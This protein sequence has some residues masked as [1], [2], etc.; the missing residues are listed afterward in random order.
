MFAA[1]ARILLVL[2]ALAGAL[3]A[4]SAAATSDYV[5]VSQFGSYGSGNGQFIGPTYNLNW[6]SYDPINEDILVADSGN[7]R[8]QV[9]SPSGAYLRQFGTQGNG[10]GQFNGIGGIAVD[11]QSHEIVVADGNQRIQIFSSSGAYLRQFG[12]PGSGIGQFNVPGSVA[13]DPVSR[14]IVVADLNNHRVQMFN[15]YGVYLG[16]FGS[17]GTGD[18]EFTYAIYLALDPNSHHILVGDELNH[19]LQIFDQHGHYLSQFGSFG[20]GNGQFNNCP[21]GIA[22]DRVTGDIVIADYGNSRVEVFDAN[23]T[24]LSQFGSAGNGNGQFNGSNGPT[25]LDINQRTHEVVVL[26]RGNS[27]AE[28]FGL[29]TSPPPPACGPTEVSLSIEPL[30][31]TASQEFFFSAQAS[32]SPP[33]AGTVS[34]LVDGTTSAACTASMRDVSASCLH[35]LGLGTHSVIAQY[36]GDGLDPGGCSTSQVVTVV[37]DGQQGPTSTGCTVIP[38]PPFEAEPA[39]VVCNVGAGPLAAPSG[40]EITGYVEV[41]QGSA[42]LDDVPIFFGTSIFTTVLSGGNH[43]LTV[44]YSGDGLNASS[45]TT[46]PISVEVPADDIFYGDFDV[47][48]S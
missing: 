3:G 23:G 39:S 29:S 36:S 25:G 14:N 11:P 33:F 34:F 27:R 12:S 46:I 5:Y 30:A 4:G 38:D 8:V 42:V 31:T 17:A 37:P 48:P 15:W 24:Y 19:N 43:P 41:T 13:I 22:V 32:I 7:N 1:A 28:I 45:A 18:G 6:V 40:G 44:T 2:A 16:Q 47:P 9:F 10:N 20:S 35:S 21:C 26:D